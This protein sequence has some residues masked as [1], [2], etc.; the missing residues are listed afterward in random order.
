MTGEPISD[1]TVRIRP[2]T[3]G[4][5]E[6]ADAKIKASIKDQ[7]V[8]LGLDDKLFASRLA[9]VQARLKDFSTRVS[10]ARVGVDDAA[11][12]AKLSEVQAKLLKLDTDTA[13][14][15]VDPRGI[16]AAE[17][18]LFALQGQLDKL[19]GEN[20]E[21]KVKV[22]TKPALSEVLNLQTAMV[23][24]AP[25]A[26]PVLATV[27]GGVGGIATA[28]AAAGIGVGAF[29]LVAKTD[30][31]KVNDVVTALATQQKAY[32][33]AITDPARHA[34]M[35]R[36]QQIW[37]G[38]A[39]DEAAAVR[40]LQAF[41][42]EWD[43]F[44]AQFDPLVFS[45]LTVGIR[46]ASA[47]LPLLV[48]IVN[49][50]GGA[51]RTLEA[52]AATALQ[53]PYWQRF[54][55]FIAEQADPAIIS[56]GTTVGNLAHGFAGLLEAFAPVA[57]QIEGGMV[58]LSGEFANF[59][60]NAGSNSGFQAFIAYVQREGPQVVHDV[61]EIVRAVVNLGTALGPLGGVE[62]HAIATLAG[63][64]ATLAN[65]APGLVRLG[66]A[67]LLANKAVG[68]LGKD[69]TLITAVKT[70]AVGLGEAGVTGMAGFGAASTAAATE[71][72]TAAATAT[73]A[74]AGWKT[75]LASIGVGVLALGTIADQGEQFNPYT[76]NGGDQQKAVGKVLSTVSIKQAQ[77]AENAGGPAITSLFGSNGGVNIQQAVKYLT[78]Y[79]TAA[80]IAQLH[81][82]GLAKS[83]VILSND[84]LT[85]GQSW[86]SQNALVAQG[87]KN[88][89]AAAIQFVTLQKSLKSV[90]TAL[91]NLGKVNIDAT[92]AQIGFLDAVKTANDTVKSGTKTLDLHTAAGRANMQAL[93]GIAT[94][95]KTWNDSLIAQ[96]ADLTD[97]H[98]KLVQQ[99]NAF[100]TTA[101][102]MGDTKG[103][104]EAL[105]RSYHLL[106]SQIETLIEAKTGQALE[107]IATFKHAVDGLHDKYVTIH[108]DQVGNA[109]FTGA[110]AAIGGTRGMAEGGPVTGG[111]PGRD[112]VPLLAM[113]GEFVVSHDGSNLDAAVRYYARRQATPQ[114]SA[115]AAVVGSDD[116]GALLA[117]VQQQTDQLLARL[118]QLDRAMASRAR[119]NVTFSQTG[120]RQPVRT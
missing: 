67:V 83:T 87:S 52:D 3:S 27:A 92:E 59:G 23:G 116:G 21:P 54:A 76:K 20:V 17:A 32:N 8:R 62:L 45:T 105:A 48:P 61:G 16:A 11:A 82:L 75:A 40:S 43:S 114:P 37:A 97:L 15:T 68:L 111:I 1:A 108:V 66:A 86:Q 38:L 6:E 46:A 14:P 100:I 53:S 35:Q 84:Q 26:L 25:A 30:L 115:T 96:G 117:A 94:S 103:Q 18:Q 89:A 44:T 63:N 93:D 4:F 81:T 90:Q 9:I 70:A 69:V 119:R 106:P 65:S 107:N 55:N 101:E 109:V 31:G 77:A 42:T 19:D 80:Q 118:D 74:L 10:N 50:A 85:A 112:S 78:D 58:R 39:P 71:T 34:A 79:G 110:G 13:H 88:A 49:S 113:P 29:A 56:L 98:P 51:L 73:G 60:E 99:Y 7:Q 5:K 2:D 120:A 12:L 24:L 104:A 91:D 102:K 36:E 22:D 64:L 33:N 95:A 28:A 47:G 41:H 72:E 57:V